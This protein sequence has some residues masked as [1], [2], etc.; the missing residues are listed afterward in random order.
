MTNSIKYAAEGGNEVNI[1]LDINRINDEIHIQLKD[2]GKGFPSDFDP[3]S[4][5][6]SIG[7]ELVHVLI[8]QLDGQITFKNNGGACVEIKF[9]L[10]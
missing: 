2:D 8:E 9:S 6:E 4:Y 10:K 1:E 5:T 3:E 7:L